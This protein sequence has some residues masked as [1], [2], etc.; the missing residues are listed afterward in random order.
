MARRFGMVGRRA[1]LQLGA[2]FGLVKRPRA[3]F[4]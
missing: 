2:S 4:C 1:I 3:G